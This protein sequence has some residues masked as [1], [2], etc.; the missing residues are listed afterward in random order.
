MGWSHFCPAVFVHF[1]LKHKKNP[2]TLPSAGQIKAA[3]HNLFPEKSQRK[4][5]DRMSKIF[6]NLDGYKNGYFCA[7]ITSNAVVDLGCPKYTSK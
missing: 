7:V 1:P 4:I 2:L 6:L 3:Q 5:F